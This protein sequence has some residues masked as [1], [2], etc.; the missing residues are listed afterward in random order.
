[1]C[2]LQGN[3]G[4]VLFSVMQYMDLK[5]SPKVLRGVLPKAGSFSGLDNKLEFKNLEN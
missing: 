4:C 1:M 2:S 3:L 5:I